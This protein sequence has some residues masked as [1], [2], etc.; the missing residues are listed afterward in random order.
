MFQ[1]RKPGFGDCDL[2]L[3]FKQSIER[4]GFSPVSRDLEIATLKAVPRPGSSLPRFSPV[5]RDLEI[6]TKT[7]TFGQDGMPMFQSRKPGF[8]DCDTLAH[9]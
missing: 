8:G 6:A 2:S 5:S 1:S 7:Q 4:Q 9:A 3:F